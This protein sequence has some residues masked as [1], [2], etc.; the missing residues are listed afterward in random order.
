MVRIIIIAVADVAPGSLTSM[1]GRRV[2]LDDKWLL[3][4]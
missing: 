3:G 1:L 4:E 2:P